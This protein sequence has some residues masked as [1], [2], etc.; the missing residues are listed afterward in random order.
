MTDAECDVDM[1]FLTRVIREE[2]EEGEKEVNIGNSTAVNYRSILS[3]I[4][5]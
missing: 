3:N 2:E 1:L 5:S 4:R